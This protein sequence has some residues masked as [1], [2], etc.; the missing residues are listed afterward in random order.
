MANDVEDPLFLPAFANDE[1]K[2]VS[3]EIRRLQEHLGTADSSLL[4][5]TD[6]ISVLHEHLGRIQRDVNLASQRL[7]DLS[8]RFDKNEHGH[9]MDLRNLVSIPPE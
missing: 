3:A 4:D 1:N 8:Q 2:A 6:T 9:Q 5:N 7:I